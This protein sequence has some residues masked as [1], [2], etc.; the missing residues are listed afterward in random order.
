[1]RD[2]RLSALFMAADLRPADVVGVLTTAAQKLRSGPEKTGRSGVETKPLHI[3][4]Q[5]EKD[6]VN[7]TVVF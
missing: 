7:E 3:H 6:Y 5:K 1:M 4:R 2:S